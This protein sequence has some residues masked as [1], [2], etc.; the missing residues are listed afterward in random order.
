LASTSASAAPTAP[1]LTLWARTVAVAFALLAMSLA[2]SLVA[3]SFIDAIALSNCS[4]QLMQTSF[5][6]T[7]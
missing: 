3:A 2:C 1:A 4:F 5:R 7:D 6:G